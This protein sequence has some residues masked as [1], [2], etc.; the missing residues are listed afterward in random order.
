MGADLSGVLFSRCNLTRCDMT[1]ARLSGAD[2]R[3][4]SIE[5][6]KVGLDELQGAIVDPSQALSFASL[7]GL[8]VKSEED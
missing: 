1:G 2:F 8:V 4:S 3:G 7:L 6:L 5:G